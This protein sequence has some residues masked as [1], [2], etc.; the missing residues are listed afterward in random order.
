MRAPGRL[1]AVRA[2]GWYIEQYRQA[3]AVNQPPG[4]VDRG[5]RSQLLQLATVTEHQ[6]RQTRLIF[7]GKTG[8]VG[9][10]QYVRTMLMVSIVCNGNA[11]FVQ[12]GSPT[13]KLYISLGW[14]SLGKL[15]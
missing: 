7:F 13:K 12:A 8:H 3:Q 15:C 14:R 10:R 2:I 5:N 11:D 9:K 4:T 1:R 6:H